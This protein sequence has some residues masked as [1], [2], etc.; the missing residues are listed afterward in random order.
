[1]SEWISVEDELPKNDLVLIINEL[2]DITVGSHE[3]KHDGACWRVGNDCVSWDYDFNY[4]FY[5][6]HWQPLPEPPK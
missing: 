4:E 5:V 6:T 3:I 2:G 1:M